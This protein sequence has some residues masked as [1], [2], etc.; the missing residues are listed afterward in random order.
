[1]RPA[2]R[3]AVVAYLEGGGVVFGRASRQGRA[4]LARSTP[5]YEWRRSR[6]EELREQPQGLVAEAAVRLPGLH[7]LPSPEALR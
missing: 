3:L 1:M 4:S 7:V 5:R 2:E 6:N